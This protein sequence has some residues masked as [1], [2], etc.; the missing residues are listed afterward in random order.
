MRGRQADERTITGPRSKWMISNDKAGSDSEVKP[1]HPEGPES[2]NV[3]Q[4]EMLRYI[5]L[6]L[7]AL[8]RRR[9]G[10]GPVIEN[11]GKIW[12]KSEVIGT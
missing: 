1:E 9:M 5:A 11:R 10:A 6:L 12:K 3:T 7:E 2:L 4:L 8:V